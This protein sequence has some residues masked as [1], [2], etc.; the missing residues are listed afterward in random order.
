MQFRGIFRFERPDHP[1][2]QKLPEGI[3]LFHG[4]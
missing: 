1:G 4:G 3:G 2:F